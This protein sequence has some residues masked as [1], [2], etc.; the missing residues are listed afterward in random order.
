MGVNQ[1]PAST[2]RWQHGQYV[3]QLLFC[4]KSQICQQAL[5][6]EKNKHRFEMLRVFQKKF[7]AYLTKF[8]NNKILLNIKSFLKISTDIQAFYWVKD[9]HWKRSQG[10]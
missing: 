9:P 4:E 8:R 7:D 2:S 3:L 1:L 6:L 10:V 5:K